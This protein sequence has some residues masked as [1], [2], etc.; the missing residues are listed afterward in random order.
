M[1]AVVAQDWA[2]LQRG[3]GKLELYALVQ[4][5]PDSQMEV[6]REGLQC[7]AGFPCADGVVVEMCG[8]ASGADESLGKQTCLEA[9]RRP[10]CQMGD[11]G[12]AF[13]RAQGCA[14]AQ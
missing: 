10:A 11:R 12:A 7:A 1:V 3:L 14:V 6:G 13:L 8:L 5:E 2:N 9:R 4:A